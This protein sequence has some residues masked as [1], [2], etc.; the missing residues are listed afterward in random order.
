MHQ[1]LQYLT[2]RCISYRFFFFSSC[3]MCICMKFPLRSIRRVIFNSVFKTN[4]TEGGKKEF[5][6]LSVSQALQIAGRA[7]RFGTQYEHVSTASP[8]PIHAFIYL[9][10]YFF[11]FFFAFFGKGNFRN[12]IFWPKLP[13]TCMES[14]GQKI[15]FRKFPLPKKAK[16]H[17]S[18]K[19]PI[20]Y[21]MH[22]CVPSPSNKVAK[23][24]TASG[25][26][27]TFDNSNPFANLL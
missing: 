16:K 14:L 17:E 3:V 21:Y 7:G 8:V 22:L 5:G 4:T 1:K 19:S 13:Q 6:S 26:I 10:I 25:K 27:L 20:P 18:R 24:I 23:N 9:F 11:F 15:I 12:I 2:R